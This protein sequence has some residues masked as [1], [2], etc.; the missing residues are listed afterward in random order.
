MIALTCFKS[1]AREVPMNYI[2]L[3]GFTLTE[4]YLVSF[5][6]S[7]YSASIVLMAASLTTAVVLALTLYACT[8]KTDFTMMGGILFVFLC[9][10]L[11]FGFITIF[12]HTKILNLIYCVC[13]VFLFSIYLIYDTQVLKIF[14]NYFDS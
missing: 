5:I 12:V 7:F 2:L 8:T 13:G 10:L 14:F 3:F 4:G 1:A 11:C 9:L 6:C